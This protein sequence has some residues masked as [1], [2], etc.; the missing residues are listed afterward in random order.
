MDIDY[1]ASIITKI[2]EAMTLETQ[3]KAYE[4]A[5]VKAIIFAVSPY[6][7]KEQVELSEKLLS[8]YYL[9]YLD[10]DVDLSGIE[11]P[12]YN[13]TLNKPS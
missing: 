13:F 6:P 8:Q 10:V 5:S 1:D 4:D 3:T 11:G 12:V 2:A 7:N 9:G